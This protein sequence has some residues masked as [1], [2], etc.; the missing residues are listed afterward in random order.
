MFAAPVLGVSPLHLGVIGLVTTIWGIVNH[1]QVVPKLGW[2]EHILVTPANHRAHHGSQ[3]KYLDVNYG[4]TLLLFDKLFGT[5]QL[6]EERPIFGLVN[7]VEQKNPF[8]FQAEGFRSLF[9]QMGSA[10]RISDKLR[11]LVLPPGWSH[12]GDHSTADVIK[13]RAGIQRRRR[14][15]KPSSFQAAHR[16]VEP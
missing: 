8:L 1:T 9:A 12:L 14:G 7:Q 10:P 13:A 3:P 4:Q 11:Y 2:L 16:S 15:S 5:H 6:E